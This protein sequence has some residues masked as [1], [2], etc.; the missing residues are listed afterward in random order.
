[1]L[2]Y[3]EIDVPIRSLDG[4]GGWHVFAGRAASH[5]EALL[6]VCTV[7]EQAAAAHA[8][9]TPVP[10][11]RPDGW[12]A[13]GYRAGWLPDWPAARSRCLRG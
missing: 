13:R 9:G 11:R 6:I 8:A 1:M 5:L 7:Y 3:Y 12:G 4:A 2:S 10:A